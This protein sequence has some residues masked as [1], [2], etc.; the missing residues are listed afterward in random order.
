VT[1]TVEQVAEK[2]GVSDRTIRNMIKDKRL[3]AFRVG[4]RQW[5]IDQAD[6]D[7]YVEEQKRRAAAS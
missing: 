5:R 3:K 7:A 4:Q 6:L 1:I 2:L